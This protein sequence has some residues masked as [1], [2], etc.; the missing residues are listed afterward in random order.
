MS[1]LLPGVILC[2]LRKQKG[3]NSHCL[4]SRSKLPS[5]FEHNQGTPQGPP[6]GNVFHITT[7]M[8]C[9]QHF[10]FS[11]KILGMDSN[12]TPCCRVCLILLF[13]SKPGDALEILQ[14]TILLSFLLVC[15]EAQGWKGHRPPPGCFAT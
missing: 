13:L 7:Q 6:Q 9:L 12:F 15:E 3:P 4:W 10:P 1:Y 8:A 11:E 5:I 2:R 14:E